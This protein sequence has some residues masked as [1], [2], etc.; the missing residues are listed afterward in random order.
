[1]VP[2]SMLMRPSHKPNRPA[3]ALHGISR[4]RDT[5]PNWTVVMLLLI[6]MMLGKMS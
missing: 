1:M 4:R 2:G 6:V 3:T 5:R